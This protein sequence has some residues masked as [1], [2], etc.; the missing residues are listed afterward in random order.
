MSET[1]LAYI[2]LLGGEFFTES[3]TA[4]L[5]DEDTLELWYEFV[6]PMVS[7]KQF[8][9]LYEQAIALLIC[10]KIKLAGYG[11]NPLGDL[12]GIGVGLSVGSVSEGGSSIS[13]G[14]SQS[15]VLTDDAELGLTV[16][17]LQ[18]LQLRRS[19]IVPIHCGGE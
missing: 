7:K 14:A 12:G 17:G 6:Y 16:Y 13:Y 18:Y 3:D 8:G 10:H 11:E 1:I 15:S 19:V 4:T 9:K 2:K 5:V